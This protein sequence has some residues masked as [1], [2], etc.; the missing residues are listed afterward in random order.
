MSFEN[1]WIINVSGRNAIAVVFPKLIL[2]WRNLFAKV[3]NHLRFMV[4]SYKYI[5]LQPLKKKKTI[6][7]Q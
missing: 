2:F 4:P 3:V 5:K 6:K 7:M 1:F